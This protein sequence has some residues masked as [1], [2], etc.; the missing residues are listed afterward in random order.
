MNAMRRRPCPR[1][2]GL[3]QLK[4]VNNAFSYGFSL[5]FAYL[6]S[7]FEGWSALLSLTNVK[8]SAYILAAIGAFC[9]AV[10]R[11]YLIKFNSCKI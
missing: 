6:L 1:E 3:N 11:G 5:L 9:R 2:D 4:V 10:F 8:D 7:F